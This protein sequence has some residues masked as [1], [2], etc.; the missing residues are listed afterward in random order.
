ME[1]N[2]GTQARFNDTGMLLPLMPP[3]DYAEGVLNRLRDD[4]LM[5]SVP[6]GTYTQGGG[7]LL[8]ATRL[9]YELEVAH[10]H[11]P[12]A[13]QY[14]GRSVLVADVLRGEADT[15][16]FYAGLVAALVPAGFKV[17]VNGEEYGAADLAHN[18]ERFAEAMANAADAV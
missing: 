15:A 3:T 2:E 6:L 10:Q 16:R 5:E 1:L 13:M 9:K 7:V 18:I 4:N 17:E 8:S 14:G 12:H 11:Q